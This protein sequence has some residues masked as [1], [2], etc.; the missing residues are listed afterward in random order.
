MS[1]IMGFTITFEETSYRKKIN[2]PENLGSDNKIVNTFRKKQRK[3][4]DNA[5]NY[6]VQ[7][8]CG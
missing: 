6:Y 1:I 4:I 3:S 7:S 8:I 2:N 5:T